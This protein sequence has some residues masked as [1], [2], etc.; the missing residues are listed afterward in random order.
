M[1]KMHSNSLFYII[2]FKLPIAKQQIAKVYFDA[3]VPKNLN[4]QYTIFYFP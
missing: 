2:Y 3:T 1:N 4:K